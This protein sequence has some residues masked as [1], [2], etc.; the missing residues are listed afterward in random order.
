M[1]YEVVAV[2]PGYQPVAFEVS[3]LVA[4]LMAAGIPVIVVDD[5][6]ADASYLDACAALGVD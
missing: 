2:V 3:V 6:S 4:P 1:P 5:G